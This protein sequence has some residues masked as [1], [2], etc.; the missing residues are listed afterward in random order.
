MKRTEQSEN[1]IKIDNKETSND[2]I[3]KLSTVI[4]KFG[5]TINVVDV[6]PEHIEYKI[7]VLK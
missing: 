3:R 4:E 5:I 6:Q 1:T 2:V 7:D